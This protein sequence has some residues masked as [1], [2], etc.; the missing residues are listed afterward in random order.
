MPSSILNSDDGVISGTSGLKS[1]GGDD[2]NLVFQSKGTETARINTDKQIVAAAGTVSLPIY[3][4]T[5]DLNTGIF[6]PAA[7]NIGFATNGVI[8]GRWTTDGLC[9]NADTAAANA[10]DDYEEGTWTPVLQG[11]NTAGTY[12]YDTDR[13]NGKY[14]KIGKMVT[15]L[16]AYRVSSITS[17]GTGEGRISGLP[18]T[19]APIDSSWNRTP[20][21]L[22]V[23]GGPTLANNGYF[24][25][26]EN[27]TF[28]AMG[29][30][31]VATWTNISVTDADFLDAVWFFQITYEAD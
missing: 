18:F 5:G 23:Q 27:S 9:F 28:L 6:F 7:D 21:D 25:L 13:T 12:V 22:N 24:C 1:S 31:G 11:S 20:G 8:R 29:L 16:G 4:T 14:I 19:S 26:T 17:A 3:S 2:G 10:L 30:Q 15:I